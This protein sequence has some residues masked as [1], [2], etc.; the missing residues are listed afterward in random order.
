MAV[1]IDRHGQVAI[2]SHS[3]IELLFAKGLQSDRDQALFDLP[4]HSRS[5]C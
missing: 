4:L 5:H 3:E 1:K 2:L